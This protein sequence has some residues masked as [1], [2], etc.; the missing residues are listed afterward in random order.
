MPPA[1]DLTTA[2]RVASLAPGAVDGPTTLPG[3]VDR[4]TASTVIGLHSDT[5]HELTGNVTSTR[6]NDG[7]SSGVA[8]PGTVDGPTTLQ[9][10]VDRS[11][12]ST[13]IGLPSDTPDELAENA[14]A[15]ESDDDHPPGIATP[16]SVSSSDAVQD[17]IN[18]YRDGK[19][20]AASTTPADVEDAAATG[21]DNNGA[22]GVAT[23]G[24]MDGSTTLP[25]TIDG[26][27]SLPGTIDG[28]NCP[29]KRH[30]HA[31]RHSR[32]AHGT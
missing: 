9:G 17:L 25:G 5:Q 23:P 15:A 3:T 19:N 10:T 8:A 30:R 26:P 2:A 4:S 24:I 12:A 6:S 16:G 29:P 1:L 28:V 7:S 21:S 31:P 18:L 14:T 32:R 22:S 11:T 20:E 13:V 27:T